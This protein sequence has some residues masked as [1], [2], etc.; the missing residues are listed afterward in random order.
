MVWT[1]LSLPRYQVASYDAN[2]GPMVPAP[3]VVQPAPCVCG[4]REGLHRWG[5]GACPN[6]LWKCGNGQ[7][8]WSTKY[9]YTPETP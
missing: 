8:Q 9:S 3:K 6:R 1:R 7:P 4:M 5:D 2:R